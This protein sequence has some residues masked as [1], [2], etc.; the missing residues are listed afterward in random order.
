MR[1]TPTWAELVT[2]M[3]HGPD[4]PLHGRIRHDDGGEDQ[5]FGWAGSADE[6]APAVAHGDHGVVVVWR[7]GERLRLEDPDGRV[8]LVC[9]GETVWHLGGPGEPAREGRPGHVVYGVD[10]TALLERPDE[11][12]WHGNDFTRPAG[13]I[14]ATTYLGRAAWT[15]ELAPPR[16]KP[17]PLQ[18]VVDAETGLL[19]QQRNDGFGAVSEWTE[20]AVGVALLPSLFTWNGPVVS[21]E[22]QRAQRR[23]QEA[24]DERERATWTREQLGLSSLLVEVRPTIDVGFHEADG[25]FHAHL[26][27]VGSLARRP[28]SAAPWREMGAQSH[29]WSDATWDWTLTSH[30]AP[31]AD[32]ALPSI[33]QQLRSVPTAPMTPDAD[34]GPSS[35]RPDADPAHFHRAIAGGFTAVVDG[36]TD[37]DAPAPVAGWTARD[38]VR[39]LVEW[40]PA[41]LESGAGVAIPS[42]PS[43]DD[44]PVAAWHLHSDSVQALLDDPASAELVLSNPHIGE[45]PVPQAV[46]RFYTADVF[47]HT[48]DLA[49]ATGQPHHMDQDL[50]ADTLAGM[51]P[52]DEMLRQSGQYGA[53][54]EVPSEVDPVTRLM[55]FV[56]RRPR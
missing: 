42:G 30:E 39:H 8:T 31:L 45:V 36:T 18:L 23:D 41:F 52:M 48:W 25:T 22:E 35:M 28:R 3:T 15:V 44:D 11:D 6:P 9:D 50:A 55:G 37:W 29:H 20:L 32:G 13:P 54:V 2:L 56:G 27:G 14:G 24:A 34:D 43:V 47:M 40:L 53:K 12:R 46:S 10:G 4:L 33:Q 49:T 16:H 21:W 51:E 1:P 19:L 17:H 38:V 5:V 7:D 26:D